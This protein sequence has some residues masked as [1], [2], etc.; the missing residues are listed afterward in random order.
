MEDIFESLKTFVLTKEDLARHPI[1]PVDPPWNKGLTGYTRTPCSEE[2]KLKISIAKKGKPA[3][4]KG[5]CMSKEQ[6]DKISIAQSNKIKSEESKEKIRNS[7]L[8]KKR[9]PYKKKG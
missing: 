9:G 5:T 3:A 2:T 8:G 6:K 4:N 1:I 7:L